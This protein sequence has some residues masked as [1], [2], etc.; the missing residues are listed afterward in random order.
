MNN[1]LYGL[2]QASANWYEMLSK[3]LADRGFKSSKVDPCVFISDKAFVLVYV[4][5]CIVISK[6]SG[7]VDKFV[8]S[9]KHGSENF[10]F[11]EE[12]LLENYLKVKFVDYD[13]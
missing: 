5:D 8:H 9:L 10:E 13:K 12:G 11:T 1:S 3:G 4:D 6:E 7:F 2:K